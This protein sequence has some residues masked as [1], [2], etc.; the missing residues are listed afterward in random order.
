[1]EVATDMRDV[2]LDRHIY[3]RYLQAVMTLSTEYGG[4]EAEPFQ[5]IITT[6]SR[7]PENL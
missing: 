5:Y 3:N 1:M 2:D 7:Q 6:T 4:A